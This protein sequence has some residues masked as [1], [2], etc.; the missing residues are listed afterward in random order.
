MSEKDKNKNK[1]KKKTLDPETTKARKRQA[2]EVLMGS[3]PQE[4]TQA[5]VKSP[6]VDE[7]AATFSEF[8]NKKG[9]PS[10]YGLAVGRAMNIADQYD[11]LNKERAMKKEASLDLSG[12][13][14]A[15][16]KRSKENGKVRGAGIAQKGVRKCKMVKA[17]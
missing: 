13:G 3:I 15:R 9:M 10:D 11:K 1:N 2:K 16:K 17:K 14:L 5:G 4:L 7:S 8:T 12:G 6:T